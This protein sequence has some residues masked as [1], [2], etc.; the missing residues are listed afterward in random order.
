MS[1]LSPSVCHEKFVNERTEN[2]VSVSESCIFFIHESIIS[3]FEE[4]EEVVVII[5]IMATE[6]MK[7]QLIFG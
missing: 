2:R 1:Q 7:M 4:E 3:N 6:T 5:G